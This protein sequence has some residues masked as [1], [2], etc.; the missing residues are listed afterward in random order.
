MASASS[1]AILATARAAEPRT[2]QPGRGP[3]S[4]RPKDFGHRS[5]WWSCLLS[6]SHTAVSTSFPS[7]RAGGRPRRKYGLCSRGIDK[8]RLRFFFSHPLDS[9]FL[10][11][12]ASGLPSASA[13]TTRKRATRD[14][15]P[16]AH[17]SQHKNP[18]SCL[19]GFATMRVPCIIPTSCGD[20][21]DYIRLLRVWVSRDICLPQTNLLVSLPCTVGISLSVREWIKTLPVQRLPPSA[22]GITPQIPISPHHK[23]RR[24]GRA[25]TRTVS[26]II[27]VRLLLLAQPCKHGTKA[28]VPP[29][30]SSSPL[31][32]STSRP[33][34]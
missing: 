1:A 32:E 27:E 26:T 30:R 31:P 22:T 6:G 7:P 18:S 4:K 13:W 5:G 12:N 15:V 24:T 25:E 21:A 23:P 3:V 33:T 2:L 28:R 29:S 10:R 34:A 17:P 9:L 11:W 19:G 20:Y 8:A 16:L 14:Q